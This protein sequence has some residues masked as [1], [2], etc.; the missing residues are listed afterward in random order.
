MRARVPRENRLEARFDERLRQTAVVQHVAYGPLHLRPIPRHEVVLAR[1]EQTLRV[2]PWRGYERNAARE[3]LEGA[4]G[5]DAWKRA[6]VRPARHVNGDPVCRK[7]CS[8]AVVWQPAVEPDARRT[9]AG[10]GLL[11]VPNAVDVRS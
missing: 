8:D 7:D 10:H 11:R 3:R 2:L 6:H 9:E 1:R 5:G 4:N